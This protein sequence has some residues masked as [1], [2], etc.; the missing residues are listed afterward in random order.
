[1]RSD[2]VAMDVGG[3]FLLA[4]PA[5]SMLR[6]AGVRSLPGMLQRDIKNDY[7]RRMLPGHGACAL[8]ACYFSSPGGSVACPV[9]DC[10]TLPAGMQPTGPAMLTHERSTMVVHSADPARLDRS[11]NTSLMDIPQLIF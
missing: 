1:M 11:G 6:D 9:S 4:L 7:V 3:M 10:A 2:A 5:V 8:R